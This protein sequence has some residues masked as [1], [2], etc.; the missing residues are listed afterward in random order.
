M[1]L[2]SGHLELRN[3]PLKTN[4][5]LVAPLLVSLS[6]AVACDSKVTECNKLADIVNAG[7]EAM[8]KI[9]GGMGDDPSK[10]AADARAMADLAKKTKSDIDAIGIKTEELKPKAASYQEMMAEM[11]EVGT[12]FADLLDKANT[13]GGEK[14]QAAEKAF[15]DSQSGLESACAEQSP[16]CTKLSELMSK[17]PPNPADEE[18]AAMLDKYAKDLGALQLEDEATKK[19]VADHKTA[20]EAYGKLMAEMN[21]IDG[22]LNAAEKR[23]DEVVEKEDKI[24]A[25]LNLYCVGSATP[26]E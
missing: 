21:D 22:K 5:L 18:V 1:L 3:R 23:L 24:V 2:P 16:D 7:V 12:E 4:S 9:E 17:Q 15:N 20:V 14:L 8:G 26:A 13:V 11:G 25:D 19:A 10:L 6:F